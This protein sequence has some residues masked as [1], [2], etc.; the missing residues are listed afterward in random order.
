MAVAQLAQL[1]SS[2]SALPRGS[3]TRCFQ[4]SH[5][6]LCRAT[7][8]RTRVQLPRWPGILAL[9]YNNLLFG[10]QTSKSLL[11]SIR[12]TWH[13]V[14][15]NYW[16]FYLNLDC[17]PERSPFPHVCLP[18]LKLGP[19]TKLTQSSAYFNLNCPFWPQLLSTPVPLNVLIIADIIPFHLSA[20]ALLVEIVSPVTHGSD[21]TSSR[22]LEPLSY[23]LTELSLGYLYIWLW[24]RSICLIMLREINQTWRENINVIPFTWSM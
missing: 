21:V 16:V 11:L 24:L 1:A 5:G 14:P 17:K 19:I 3:G 15:G 22:N 7:G 20:F 9:F 2:S 23:V 18:V 13:C 4:A 12:C 6:A 8:M 10:R